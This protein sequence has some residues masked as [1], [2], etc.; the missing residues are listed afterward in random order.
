MPAN[1]EWHYRPM[2][3]GVPVPWRIILKLRTSTLAGFE[4]G[5]KIYV[6]TISPT[7]LPPCCCRSCLRRGQLGESRR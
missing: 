7:T 6:N 4:G 1:E 2:G 3:T 5:T